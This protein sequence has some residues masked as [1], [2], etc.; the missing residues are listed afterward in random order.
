M[1]ELQEV[2]RMAT[3][4]IRPEPGA[5]E[6]QFQ[7][8]RRRSARRKAA[9]VGLVAALA[10]V[11]GVIAVQASRISGEDRSTTAGTGI[12]TNGGPLFAVDG[13]GSGF[14]SDGSRLLVL[15]SRGG[16]VVDAASGEVLRSV[17]AGP[18]DGPA[19]FSPDGDLFVTARGCGQCDQ[20]SP[21]QFLHTHVIQTS[22]G[23]ELWDFRKA[24]CFVAFSPDGRLLALPYAG[25]TQVVDL[26]TGEPVNEFEAFGS[27]AF[28]PDGQ[29]LVVGS[30]DEGVVARVFDVGE[31]SD[32]RPVVTLH[33][34][35]ADPSAI[36]FAWS[37]DGSTL[38]TSMNSSEA[39]VWDAVTGERMLAIPSPTGRIT[40]VAF[41]SD[42]GLLATGSSDGDAVVWDL[43]NGDA[44]PVATRHVGMGDRDWLTVALS[45]DG[46]RLM[47]SNAAESTVWQIS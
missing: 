20:V 35:S 1:P 37:P 25:R 30:G 44:H 23:E 38:V 31:L 21:V 11:A 43:S 7:G 16:L 15:T 45:P 9:A 17:D 22:T 29:Q 28:S 6:R 3:Q 40:S 10:I 33:G 19:G 42:V 8:Q 13:D 2:F 46:T 4:K 18:G 36:K 47:A 39:S 27:F 26:G 41:A 24:C 34:D 5:L 14:T 32:G 12:S